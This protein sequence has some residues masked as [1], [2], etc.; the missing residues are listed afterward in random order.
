MAIVGLVTAYSCRIVARSF[1]S[2][3]FPHRS[4]GGD[5]LVFAREREQHGVGHPHAL[6]GGAASQYAA[7]APWQGTPP[8]NLFYRNSS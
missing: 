4:A 8:G 7:G 2:Q 5:A 1:G 6:V 3:A